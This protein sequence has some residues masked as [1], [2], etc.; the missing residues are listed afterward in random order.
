MKPELHFRS[1]MEISDQIRRREVTSL[2]V[3]EALLGRIEVLDKTYISYLTVC[4]D[5]A[6]EQARQADESIGRG[7]WKGPLHGVPL[8]IKD[9][10]YTTFAPTTGGMTQHRGFVPQFNATVVDRLEVA[11]AVIL[12]KL[13]M[14]EGAYTSHHP[15]IPPPPNPWGHGHWVGSSSTGSGVATSAGMC[16]GSLGSDTGGSIRFPSATCGLTGIKPTWGRVSRYGNFALADSLDHLGPMARSAQDCAAILQ[17]IAGWDA[18]DPTSIDAPVPDY[19]AAA[20]RSIRDLSIGIDPAYAYDGV[21]PAVAAALKDAAEIFASLGA[22]IVE[23]TMPDYEELVA[24]WIM[25]CSVETAAAHLATY[26]QHADE[27]GPE[28]KQL[29]DQGHNT[30]G[31][32]VARGTQRRLAFTEALTGMLDGIDCML[33]PAM[34]VPTPSLA[35][36]AEYGEDPSIL[37]AILRYTAPF[38]FSGHPSITFPNGLDADGLP[39][40]MQVIGRKLDEDILVTVGHAYQTMTD[41]HRRH[42]AVD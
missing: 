35:Q 27:Y 39:L 23:V 18:N 4:A 6:I 29:I 37:N 7:V 24:S 41:W 30:S 32:D 38:D 9:L 11:G 20:G 15:D 2:E 22:R 16:Y 42:P 33:C 28:L 17:A 25:M 31:I 34:P 12:G 3:T 14:T 1:L 26:P 40:S 19:L 5:R 8:G 10:C 21:D 13:T 36:M